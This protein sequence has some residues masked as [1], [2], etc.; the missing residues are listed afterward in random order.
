MGLL[1][2]LFS[3]VKFFAIL[4]LFIG[5]GV[6]IYF[7]STN[8]AH[9]RV[10]VIHSLLS[11]KY[12]LAPDTS[13]PI[14]SSQYVAYETLLKN[15]PLIQMHPSM[16]L[17]EIVKEMRDS[18][19]FGVLLPRPTQCQSQEKS[20]TVDG[21]QFQYYLVHHQNDQFKLNDDRVL[22]YLHGGGY[23]VGDF[24]SEILQSISRLNQ[25]FY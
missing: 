13:R 11:V 3:L 10:R 7:E 20:F 8:F 23:V 18:F 24:A 19:T 2:G 6:P 22:L 21:R 14:L 1:S 17:S 16:T 25:I 4:A 15:R 5:I 9:L 12:S